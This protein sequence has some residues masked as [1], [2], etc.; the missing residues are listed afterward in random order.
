MQH[1]WST[2]RVLHQRISTHVC[3]YQTRCHPLR[4]RRPLMS[5]WHLHGRIKPAITPY[6]PQAL[7][8]LYSSPAASDQ[9]TSTIP[10]STMRRAKRYATTRTEHEPRHSPDALSRNAS[11][12][13]I[14]LPSNT[15]I[16]AAGN[17]TVA[18]AA[19]KIRV[20]R[21]SFDF[22]QASNEV[23]IAAKDDHSNQVTTT[24]Y[25]NNNYGYNPIIRTWPNNDAVSFLQNRTTMIGSDHPYVFSDRMFRTLTECKE[26]HENKQVA[27]RCFESLFH[28]HRT[29]ARHFQEILPGVEKLEAAIIM[30]R[31]KFWKLSPERKKTRP[32][33]TPPGQNKDR[34]FL[35]R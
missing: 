11:S 16:S 29:S 8:P 13:E 34:K 21:Q 32:L 23:Q 3:I 10:S 9:N 5:S 20:D 33:R 30:F 26:T 27:R 4:P 17:A 25:F 35:R 19:G 28:W 7:I 2:W 22:A 15:N 18:N 1:A 14:E 6:W 12:H 31:E 24:N